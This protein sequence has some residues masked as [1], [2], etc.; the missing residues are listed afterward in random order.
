MGKITH[1]VALP[2]D[3]DPAVASQG[4]HDALVPQ[5]LAPG[6]ELLRRTAA[7]F[8]E[9]RQRLTKAVRIE[10][11]DS[12]PFESSPENSPDRRCGAPVHPFQANGRKL[13]VSSRSDVCGGK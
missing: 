5:V 3:R 11:T 9:Q 7:R 2:T 4:G 1:D 6:F 13:E 8:A 12:G 10:V